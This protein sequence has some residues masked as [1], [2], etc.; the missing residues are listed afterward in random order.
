MEKMFK[1][2]DQYVNENKE[3]LQK[4]YAAIIASVFLEH[5]IQLHEHLTV[6]DFLN[7]KTFV[8]ALEMRSIESEYEH[9]I[10]SCMYQQVKNQ[11]FQHLFEMFEKEEMMKMLDVKECSKIS[12][13]VN[14]ETVM[15]NEYHYKVLDY[16]SNIIRHDYERLKKSLFTPYIEEG[17]KEEKNKKKWEKKRL[18][19]LMKRGNGYERKN[20][21]SY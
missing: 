2:I 19:M 11:T 15:E 1:I 8:T 21:G 6:N 13:L 18:R 20:D 3:S 9:F 5:D 16:I 12:K 4:D 17:L 10:L 7:R 14:L